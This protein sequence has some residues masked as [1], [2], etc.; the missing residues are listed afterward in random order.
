MSRAALFVYPPSALVVLAPLGMLP[1]R[2]AFAAWDLVTGGLFVWVA[3]RIGAGWWFLLFLPV[4]TVAW[5]GGATFLIGALVTAGLVA[6]DKPAL[7]GLLFGLAA[8]VKPQL[9]VL[10]PIALLAESRW[11]TLL[12]AAAA[13]AA[14]CLASVAL[15][16]VDLWRAWWSMLPEYERLASTSPAMLAW[17]VT[18]SAWLVRHGVDHRW[19]YLLVPPVVWGLWKTF[20]NTTRLPERVFALFAG[21]LLVTPYAMAYETALLAPALVV[22]ISRTSASRWP[23]YLAAALTLVLGTLSA[24]IWIVGAPALLACVLLVAWGAIAD[25]GESDQ[26]R[27]LTAGGPV[28]LGLA[29]SG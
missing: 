27:E 23:A 17:E 3:R 13:G 16:G 12:S 6:R 26:D 15:W 9:L 18:P 22:F 4:L 29:P 20:R 5:G 28:E 24:K 11:R 8:A 14:V 1:W 21:T 2:A 7:A 10:V 19:A 25:Q